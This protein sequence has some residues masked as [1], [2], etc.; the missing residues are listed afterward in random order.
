MGNKGGTA[1]SFT[2]ND[3][4]LCFVNTH[5]AAHQHKVDKRNEDVA[6]VIKG[7][8]MGAKQE[9]MDILNQYHHVFWCG[10]LNYRLDFGDQE[11][12]G[13]AVQQECRDRSRMPSSA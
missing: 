4:S 3:I 10:D 13:R 1:V 8:K 5:L 7:I 12:I 2:L 11:E 9:R 6:E